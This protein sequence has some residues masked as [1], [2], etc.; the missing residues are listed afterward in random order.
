VGVYVS[1]GVAIVN[2]VSG[3]SATLAPT[4]LN[5]NLRYAMFVSIDNGTSYSINPTLHVDFTPAS[6]TPGI[7]VANLTPASVTFQPGVILAL[8]PTFYQT[9]GTVPTG[10]VTADVMASLSYT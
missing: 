8:V 2:Y 10:S 6:L 9:G 1:G 5:G 4:L 7:A 3:G